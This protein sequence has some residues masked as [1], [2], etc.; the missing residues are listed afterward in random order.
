MKRTRAIA[1][2]TLLA[3]ALTGPV[4]AGKMISMPP[5][6]ARP[7]PETAVPPA[8]APAAPAETP[9]VGT[10]ALHRYASTRGAPRDVYVTGGASHGYGYGYPY[11]YGYGYPYGYGYGFAYG[12]RYGYGRNVYFGGYA[13]FGR[14]GWPGNSRAGWPGSG[15]PFGAT[16]FGGMRF[17]TGFNARH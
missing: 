14:F 15:R 13:R 17:T 6:P 10:I 9:D 4:R 12:Y 5:P 3:A 7:A 8:T 2:V 1:V 11:G 16:R